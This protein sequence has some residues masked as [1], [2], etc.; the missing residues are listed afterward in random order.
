MPWLNRYF[1]VLSTLSLIALT[2]GFIILHPFEDNRGPGKS[3]DRNEGLELAV[4][5]MTEGKSPYYPARVFP[6]PLSVL[7]GSIIL[8][9]PFVAVGNSGYQNIFWLAV[10][11]AAM[12]WRFRDKALALILFIVPLALSPAAQYE[13]IS[14]GDLIT[15]SIFVGIFALLALES[16]SNPGKL[17]WLRW[18]A[19]ILLGLSLAS[20]ANFILLV[21]L[22]GAALWRITGPRVAIAATSIVILTT[23][24]TCLPF[25][26]QD[27]SGFTPLGSSRKLGIVNDA[28]PWAGTAMIGMTMIAAMAGTIFILIGKRDEPV[29]SFFRG[30]AWVTLTPMVCAVLLS[31]WVHGKLDF[32]F[33]HDRFGLMYVFFAL[34]GWGI[35]WSPLTLSSQEI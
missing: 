18:G 7:P 29:S 23:L 12:A 9:A 26:L 28:L 35:S 32:G 5:R 4:R 22:F 34:L 19:C 25:Y 21:P 33:L 14:G 31:S 6:G 10:F 17:G 1:K 16:W 15:N 30:C 11:L 3:S 13:F 2:V 8:S 20:R 24:A 27:P